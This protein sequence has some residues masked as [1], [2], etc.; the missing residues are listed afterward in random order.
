MTTDSS[1][2][3]D[4]GYLRRLLALLASAAFFQGYDLS[5]LALL[6]PD[7]QETFDVGEA[8]LG[9][10]RIPIE[11][12]LVV[13]FFV[14]RLADRV[15][16]RPLLL[17]SVLGYTAFTALTVA[18][19]DLWSFA[20]FQFGARV[21][22]GAEVV[23]AVTVVVEEFPSRRRGR[24]LGVLLA[25]EAAGT[26]AVALLVAAGLQG[27]ALGWRSFFL[28]GLVPLLGLAFARRRLR[29]T[30]RFLVA[31]GAHG[32]GRAPS[33]GLLAPWRSPFRRMLVVV[34]LVHLFRSVPLFGAT[35][36][37]AF[38]AQRERG[39]SDLEVGVAVLGAFSVGAVA[40]YLCG[41]AMDRFGRRPTAVAYLAGSVVST[42]VLFQTHD[43]LLGHVA[44]VGAVSLGLGAQ[45]VLSAF[46]TELFPTAIRGQ[47]AA[48]IRNVFEVP[49]YVLGPAAVGVLG[50]RAHGPI[51]NIG[52]SVTLLTLWAIPA[53]W[54]VWRRLPET[55]GAEL[56]SLECGPSASRPPARMP[57]GALRPV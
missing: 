45:P 7:L 15:G 52:D 31:R 36:W 6:L 55:R 3:A 53:I 46:S 24:A 37:W 32:R 25:W 40:Y 19:W 56:E 11:L 9:L 1:P 38:F 5:V 57:D 22:L 23:V 29:E 20:F 13:A 12:G 18:A 33:A 50:D 28:V 51:G 49:G 44:L 42:M 4:D 14:A 34:G 8:A 2:G 41:R 17:W 43:R 27:T 47:A 30:S 39:F 54:L 10:F 48:W 16:R 35:A 21:F 26:I